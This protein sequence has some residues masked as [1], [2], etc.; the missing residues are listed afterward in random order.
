MAGSCRSTWRSGATQRSACFTAVQTQ[1]ACISGGSP[2]ALLR[3]TFST[4]SS[5]GKNSQ[6][7]IARHVGDR[8]NL[9]RRRRMAQQLAAF[10]VDQA[11]GRDPAHALDEAADDLAAVDA[12][13]DRAA[14]VD[15]QIDARHGELAGEAIDLDLGDGRALRVVQERSAAAGLAVVVDAGRGVEAVGA[16]VDAV[17]AGRGAELAEVACAASGLRRSKTMPSSKTTCS[18][19]SAEAELGIGKLPRGEGGAAAL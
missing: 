12:G 16:E 11:L 2:T 13:I 7:K 8:G 17:A 6:L 5:F 18:G 10:A 4:L 3:A 15:Q 19:D 1:I 14:D 9:V